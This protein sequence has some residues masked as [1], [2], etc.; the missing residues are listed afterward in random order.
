MKSNIPQPPYPISHNCVGVKA[1]VNC[2]VL[3]HRLNFIRINKFTDSISMLHQNIGY[4]GFLYP[5]SVTVSG[6]P[7]KCVWGRG[8]WSELYWHVVLK[9][10]ILYTLLKVTLSN[11][12]GT[13]FR[14][15]L[16]RI[17]NANLRVHS[18]NWSRAVFSLDLLIQNS[19]VSSSTHHQL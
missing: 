19:F 13:C 17:E 6:D 1:K 12:V 14:V 4:L 11:P 15:Y 10:N 3:Y 8:R 18:D 7:M 9:K 5:D 16:N 2:L